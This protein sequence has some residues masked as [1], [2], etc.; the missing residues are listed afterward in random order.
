[1]ALPSDVIKQGIERA[2][3][4]S[5]LYAVG[6]TPE[7][8][9]KP[10]VGVASCWSEGTPCNVNNHRLAVHI[11]DGIRDAGGVGKEFNT[12]SVTDGIAMGTEGMKASL[13]SREVIADSMEL[14]IRGHSYDAL[15][16]IGGCDKTNPGGLM[17]L[18]RPQR[19]RHLH[20]RR[21]HHA[22]PLSRQRRD[23]PG[24]F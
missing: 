9:E 11:K 18:A 8:F 19:S 15:V 14:Y 6:F 16:A 13:V 1:M 2:P 23:H 3:N 24:Y 10:W 5:M 12:I 22:G 4:R 17:A 20:L 21:Q 7:D